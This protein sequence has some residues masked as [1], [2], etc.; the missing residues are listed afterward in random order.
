MGIAGKAIRNL[1]K[2]SVKEAIRE[3]ATT[4]FYAFWSLVDSQNV[5][6][7]DLMRVIRKDKPALE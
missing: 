3:G 7:G 6:A 1:V 2:E 4:N 5:D